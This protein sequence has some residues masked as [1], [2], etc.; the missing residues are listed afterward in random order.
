MKK[1]ILI[2]ILV[3][4]VVT[5]LVKMFLNNL[6]MHYNGFYSSPEMAMERNTF[7][8]AFEVVDID[9]SIFDSLQTRHIEKV[10]FDST[11]IWVA[12]MIYSKPKFV[13]FNDF[14]ITD[15][16]VLAISPPIMTYSDSKYKVI[17]RFLV[18]EYK[19]NW[20]IGFG[21]SNIRLIPIK[22]SILEADTV[23]AIIRIQN[24][25]GSRVDLG[26]IKFAKKE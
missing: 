24:P 3:V 17:Y 9:S 21:L 16:L 1:A 2:V 13:F 18:P 15:S 25:G 7:V 8:Q 11:S 23:N 26:W 5:T 19:A 12:N 6:D 22:P 14:R 4:L 20:F 10:S